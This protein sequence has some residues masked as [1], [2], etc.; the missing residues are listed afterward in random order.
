MKLKNFE[1]LNINEALSQIAEQPLKGAFKFKIYNIKR[2]LEDKIEVLLKAMEGL[3]VEEDSDEIEE[4]MAVEQE[5][6]IYKIGQN[7]LDH[8]DLSI[9]Q[10]ALLES[11]IKFESEEAD[12]EE[13]TEDNNR[14]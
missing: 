7:E 10:I 9:K 3:H 11:I 8:I 1:I 14:E 5:I 12:H 4:I 2:V 6:V 13:D